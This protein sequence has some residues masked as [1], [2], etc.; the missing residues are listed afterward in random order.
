MTEISGGSLSKT[1][2]VVSPTQPS[3]PFEGQLWRDTLNDTLKQWDGSTWVSVQSSFD[4]QTIVD[5]GNGTKKV[6]LGDSLEYDGTYIEVPEKF[7][8]RGN[9]KLDGTW[10]GT[11]TYYTNASSPNAVMMVLEEIDINGFSLTLNGNTSSD[12]Y[13]QRRNGSSTSSASSWRIRYLQR[14]CGYIYISTSDGNNYGM[15]CDYTSY[16]AFDNATV[17]GKYNASASGSGTV[18]RLSFGASS[19]NNGI[20]RV[21]VL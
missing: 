20:I 19:N 9:W 7:R 10:D 6:N 18:D 14:S 12:Y 2:V 5:D 3:S 11:G 4:G 21:Y 16:T 1:F 15:M 13:Y 17:G 8:G